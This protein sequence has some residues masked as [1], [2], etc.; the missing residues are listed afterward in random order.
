[1]I[2]LA[3]YSK[4]NSSRTKHGAGPSSA[5]PH[6]TYFKNQ[7]GIQNE[8]FLIKF[9]VKSISRVLLM[10]SHFCSTFHIDTRLKYCSAT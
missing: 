9:Y 10:N 6:L 5:H 4:K 2:L 7:S 8:N 1:M 3:H